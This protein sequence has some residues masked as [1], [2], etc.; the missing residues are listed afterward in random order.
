MEQHD[1]LTHKDWIEDVRIYDPLPSQPDLYVFRI[2]RKSSPLC[3]QTVCQHWNFHEQRYDTYDGT[4]R[5]EAHPEH[6]CVLTEKQMHLLKDEI[7]KRVK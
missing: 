6:F 3:P 4:Y 7:N 2:V 5:S 1:P